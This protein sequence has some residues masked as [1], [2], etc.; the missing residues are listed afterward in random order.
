MRLP[1]ITMTLLLG[2]CTASDLVNPTG[3][4]R[5][6]I[7]SP[8]HLDA[9]QTLHDAG[10]VVD[11]EYLSVSFID[12]SERKMILA[13][14]RDVPCKMIFRNIEAQ[15]GNYWMPNH[16]SCEN[17]SSLKGFVGETEE[18]IVSLPEYGMVQSL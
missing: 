8:A 12:M 11:S 1:L 4:P 13:V 15:N 3:Q 2:G 16:F 18:P 10:L 9:L 5:S 17:Q 7:T 14:L 6:F